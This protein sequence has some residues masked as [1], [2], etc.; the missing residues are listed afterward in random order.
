MKPV[1]FVILSHENPDQLLR[2]IHALNAMYGDPPIACHHDFF[3]S[4]LDTNR[5]PPN[6]RLVMPYY[7]TRWG[8]FSVVQSF[9]AA[10]DLLYRDA[11]PDWFFLLSGSDY[12]AARAE[13]VIDQLRRAPCDAF[14]DVHQLDCAPPRA[15]VIGAWN[16]ALEHLESKVQYAIKERFYKRAQLWAPVIRTRPRLRIGRF[17][18]TLPFDGPHP[19]DA[20]LGLFWGD[21]WFTA[22]RRAARVLLSP[23]DRH[24]EVQRFLKWRPL[25]EESYYQTVLCGTPGLTICRDNKRFTC[26][27][28][29]GAH[30]MTLTEAEV[31]KI[32]DSGAYFARKFAPGSPALDALDGALLS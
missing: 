14:L 13:Q 16:P 15:E 31:P 30:P 1:G 17:T 7:R 25:P 26:W 3:Q 23:T 19:Y 24:L 11:G 32:L 10:L 12:P 27:N 9:L 5:L 6:V 18:V 28:G 8:K 29:G 2:L 4:N 22:N 20:G 21:H